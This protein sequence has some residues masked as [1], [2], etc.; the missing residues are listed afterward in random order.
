MQKKWSVDYKFYY[1]NKRI[2]GCHLQELTKYTL[3]YAFYYK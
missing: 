1:Y 2:L 3:W